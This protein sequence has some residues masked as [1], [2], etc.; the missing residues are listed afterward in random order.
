M[1]SLRNKGYPLTLAKKLPK[2]KTVHCLSWHG[3]FHHE[4]KFFLP[5]GTVLG[6]LLF[7]IFINDLH[8][9]TS[10]FTLLFADDTTFLVEG[11]D[12]PALIS[13]TNKE[14]AKATEWFRSN[15]LTL[16]VTKTKYILISPFLAKDAVV[17]DLNIDGKKITRISKLS[18]EKSVRFLGVWLDEDL[19]FTDHV[20]K[21]IKK[22]KTGLHKLRSARTSCPLRVRKQIYHSLFESYLLFGITIY[23]AASEPLLEQIFLLQK[24]AIR[25]VADVHYLAHTDPLF[26]EL[27]ITKFHN[28]I[29]QERSI[30]VHKYRGGKLPPS[31]S[32]DFLTSVS[33]DQIGRRMDPLCFSLPPNPQPFNHRSPHKLLIQSWNSLPFEIKSEGEP[34]KFRSLIDQKAI[35]NIQTE[36]LVENCRVCLRSDDEF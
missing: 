9:C 35:S 3:I 5:Q 27:N 32:R 28:L 23:S 7:I 16:N 18:N 1:F 29:I 8:S 21:L 19:S 2:K 13:H 30:M 11:W 31:F 4:P 15:L 10:L 12:L 17:P 34:I 36:C 24:K 14:L 25:L 20:E 22:L 33:D 6:P 26:L